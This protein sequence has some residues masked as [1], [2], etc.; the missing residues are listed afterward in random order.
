M[1]I[2]LLIYFV[3][4][5]FPSLAPAISITEAG[6]DTAENGRELHSDSKVCVYHVFI[7]CGYMH[8]C[9][10]IKE[11]K[12]NKKERKKHKINVMSFFSFC[13]F[14]VV[15]MLSL[16]VHIV[17]QELFMCLCVKKRHYVRG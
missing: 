17:P 10:Q 15:I 11:E 4:C 12:E 5:V 16:G 13:L 14:V 6:R 1:F 2:F 8:L 3:S 9:V 7:V